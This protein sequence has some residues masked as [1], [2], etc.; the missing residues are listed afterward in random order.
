MKKPFAIILG[1]GPGLGISLMEKFSRE[2]YQV[3][4]VNRSDPAPANSGLNIIT[5][6]LSDT[7]QTKRYLTDLIEKHGIPDVVVHNPAYLT[8][9]SLVETSTSDFEQSWRI[10]VLSAFNVMTLVLPE[11]AKQKSGTIIVS[12]ATASLRGSANF[13]AFASAK[14][15]LRGLTQS[16]AREYQKQ[17]GHV[18]HVILDGILDT[19]KSRELHSLSPDRMMKTKDV[20]DVYYQLTQQNASTW[21]H[22][23]DLR[24][25]SE[26]F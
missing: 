6:D 10:M 2:G 1:A 8:I 11:M 13:S 17:G 15:A 18:S 4:G 22:E 3:S 5:V 21:T 26:N 24:A 14:F 16:M 19:Q 20:A 25:F 23:L 12:G 9:S 7:D